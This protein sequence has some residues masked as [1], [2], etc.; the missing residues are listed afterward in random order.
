MY[1]GSVDDPEREEILPPPRKKKKRGANVRGVKERKT[2]VTRLLAWRA[3]AHSNDRLA[4][5]R[6]PCF[7]IDDE[8]IKILSKIHPSNITRSEQVV[9]ALGETQ[10]WED[11]WS[12]QIFE[13]IQAYDRELSDQRKDEAARSK[14]R[15]KRLKLEKDQVKFAEV[16]NEMEDRIRQEVLRR[17]TATAGRALTGPEAPMG[18]ENV[19]I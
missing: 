2:L 6:P 4:P 7:I 18:E 16:T 14:A 9:A 5:V 17:H 11:E 8:D 10:E 19:P 15:Q 3:S 12:R 1:Y 13:V